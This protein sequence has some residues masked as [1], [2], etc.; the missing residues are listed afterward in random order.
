MDFSGVKAVSIPEG[1]VNR[2]SIRGA[3]VWNSGKLYYL[4]PADGT[5]EGEIP[6]LKIPTTAGM[7]IIITFFLTKKQGY[8]YD[9]RNCGLQYL[10][11]VTGTAYPLT[12]GQVG[13]ERSVAIQP[14]NGTLTVSGFKDNADGELAS[15]AGDRLYGR[16]V[17][18]LVKGG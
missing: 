9:G 8:L 11:S 4:T 6:C 5:E 10:G 1:A 14:Q 13:A 18:V 15:N 2:I 16:Y 12:D 7:E 3:E 17:K